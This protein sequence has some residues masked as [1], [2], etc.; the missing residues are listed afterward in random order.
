MVK[1]KDYNHLYLY[2][3]V[4]L[5]VSAIFIYPRMLFA[6]GMS[7]MDFGERRSA[8]MAV[9]GNP[10][11]VSAIYHNPAAIRHLPNYS[12]SLGTSLAFVTIENRFYLA[13]SNDSNLPPEEIYTDLFPPESEPPDR[14]DLVFAASPFLGFTTNF[15]LPWAA[16]GL[17]VYVPNAAGAFMDEDSPARYHVLKGYIIAIYYSLAASFGWDWNNFSISIGG[18]ASLVQTHL[19]AE[20]YL[21]ADQM[22]QGFVFGN[23]MA[24]N[25]RF[26]PETYNSASDLLLKINGNDL[27]FAWSAS[28]FMKIFDI[29]GVGFTYYSQVDTE[30]NGNVE[31]IPSQPQEGN[32]LRT[33][34]SANQVTFLTIPMGF[35]V[36][37]NVQPLSW[38]E[39]GFDFDIFLYRVVDVQKTRLTN[40]DPDSVIGLFMQLPKENPDD[41]TRYGFEDVKDYVDSF[42]VSGGLMFHIVENEYWAKKF[43]LMVGFQYDRAPFPTK[44]YSLESPVPSS[45]G[46]GLGARWWIDSA[47]KVALV[48]QSHFAEKLDITDSITIPPTNVIAKGYSQVVFVY[49][50]LNIGALLAEE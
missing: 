44:S 19:V 17:G 16:F 6:G 47:W 26:D 13:T 30:L 3:F 9:M 34:T 49:V 4:L 24:W 18:T 36:G 37:F 28:L 41:P 23:P 50:G 5:I 20:R 40:V 38:L 48:F 29:A 12:L 43:S 45:M 10:D 2:V 42:N 14:P 39:F 21:N 22:L 31:V 7:Y 32:L 33:Y 27:E 11:E 46:F 8:M 15:G 25:L 1:K 35:R